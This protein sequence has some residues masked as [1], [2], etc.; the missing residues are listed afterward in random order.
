MLPDLA[1]QILFWASYSIIVEFLPYPFVLY[2]QDLSSAFKHQR[3]SPSLQLR[4][5]WHEDFLAGGDTGTI[6][7]SIRPF[8]IRPPLGATITF[9]H[10]C[11][12]VHSTKCSVLPHCTT[13][14][15]S[16]PSAVTALSKGRTTSGQMCTNIPHHIPLYTPL[17]Q[18]RQRLEE[19]E[20]G[21]CHDCPCF[22]VTDRWPHIPPLHRKHEAA[23]GVKHR[24]PSCQT[25]P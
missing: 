25:V 2:L 9:Y 6:P 13:P 10:V 14:R 1:Y 17:S 19:M 7:A 12:H 20:G 23:W 18:G 5:A 3:W 24:P 22:W 8:L 15:G 21:Y 11:S 16:F 4:Y